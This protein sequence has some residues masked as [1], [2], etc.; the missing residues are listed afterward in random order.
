ME[1]IEA[2][3]RM[4]GIFDAPVHVYTA[5]PTR[6]SP[7]RGVRVHHLQLLLMCCDLE[8]FAR[9]D[10]DLREQ[11]ASWLPAFGAATD[12]VMR[13]LAFDRD[14]DLVGCALA[15]QRTAGEVCGGRLEA[16]IDCRM[17]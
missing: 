14:R 16:L 8:V 3:Q 17:D 12:V 9:R 13:A 5:I 2:V 7:D 6:M 1:K 10:G 4:I 15:L 11:R